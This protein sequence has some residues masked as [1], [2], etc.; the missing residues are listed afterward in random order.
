MTK[1]Q[2]EGVITIFSKS[3]DSYDV[4]DLFHIRTHVV[5]Q[6][7]IQVSKIS[8]LDVHLETIQ[9]PHSA[10]VF[11]F[12]DVCITREEIRFRHEWAEVLLMQLDVIDERIAAQS[13]KH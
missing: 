7:D 5:E 4:E 1:S 8:V 12:A 9:I 2:V 10:P 6:Y 11:P 3:L 13:V